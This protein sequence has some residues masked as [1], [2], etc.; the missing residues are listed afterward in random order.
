MPAKV[1]F[2]I[3]KRFVLS[4][5]DDGKTV[6]KELTSRGPFGTMR[7]HDGGSVYLGT[8]DLLLSLGGIVTLVRGVVFRI[9]A[10]DGEIVA[11]TKDSYRAETWFK[12]NVAQTGK[13]CWEFVGDETRLAVAQE[14]CKLFPELAKL[15]KIART[16]LQRR[17]A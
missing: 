8:M 4:Y 10:S 17:A 5:L 12:Q 6:D 15:V 2:E 11:E 9:R 7:I 14:A 13:L 3:L 1:K 16:E